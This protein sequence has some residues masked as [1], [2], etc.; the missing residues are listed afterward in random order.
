MHR[1]VSVLEGNGRTVSTDAP[2]RYAQAH[3]GDRI[4]SAF[5]REIPQSLR[6]KTR[7]STRISLINLKQFMALGRLWHLSHKN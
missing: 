3:S 2:D 5:H 1:M 4:Q 6:E 7:V